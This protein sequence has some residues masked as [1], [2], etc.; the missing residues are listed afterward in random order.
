MSLTFTV[1]FHG[2]YSITY[3]LPYE[4]QIDI[5]IINSFGVVVKRIHKSKMTLYKIEVDVKSLPDGLYYIVARSGN[6]IYTN[7]FVKI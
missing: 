1:S 7:K 5:D 4:E 3:N 2:N 6:K